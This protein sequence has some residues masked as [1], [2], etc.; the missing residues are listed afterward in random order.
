MFTS[1]SRVHCA[2][3]AATEH[4]RHAPTRREFIHGLGASLGGIAF[5]SLLAAEESP[6]LLARSLLAPKP[7]NAKTKSL[8]RRRP[9]RYLPD[10]GR[11]ATQIDTFD[12]K[13]T[14]ERFT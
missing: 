9:E 3:R 14:L 2:S 4:A 7:L 10:D 12:P 8:S 1:S 5:A 13:P 6:K 11:R